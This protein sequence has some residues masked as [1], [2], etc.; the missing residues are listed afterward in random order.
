MWAA[1]GHRE[2]GKTLKG[3]LLPGKGEEQVKALEGETSFC[4]ISK[5]CF[6]IVL[7]VLSFFLCGVFVPCLQ[8]GSRG[9][10]II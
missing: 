6:Y 8:F 2:K 10:G 3:R 4:L 1:L 5:R 7:V 9:G